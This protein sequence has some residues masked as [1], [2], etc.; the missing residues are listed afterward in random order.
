MI[1]EILYERRGMSKELGKR[2]NEAILKSSFTKAEIARTF[3]IT[4]QAV[5]GW[6][7]TGR[8]SKELLIELAN[9]IGAKPNYLLFGYDT[10]S[11]DVG[12]GD[13]EVALFLDDDQ[14]DLLK[15]VAKK[16]GVSEDEAAQI[17]MRKGIENYKNR[18]QKG[19]DEQKFSIDDISQ[20][21]EAN[22]IAALEKEVASAV[23]NTPQEVQDV[24]QALIMRYQND[25]QDGAETAR[26][27]KKLLGI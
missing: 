14:R 3:G 10:K 21:H 6:V 20:A 11:D 12:L 9:L 18:E 13:N 25:E 5:N 16:H 22:T 7:T 15:A 23:L 17:A 24:I 2:I 26:A 27:I 4:A 1:K 8:I 19:R